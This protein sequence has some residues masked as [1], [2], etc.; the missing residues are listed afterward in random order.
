MKRIISVL[1]LF[2]LLSSLPLFAAGIRENASAGSGSSVWKISKDGNIM[3]LA[4]SIHI[5]RESD[6]PLP[7]EFDYAFSKSQILV[8]EADAD[9][10][11]DPEIMEYI[12]THMFLPGETMLQD[13]LEPETYELLSSVCEEYGIPIETLSKIK[14]S[15]IIN[16]LTL[17][18]IQGYDFTQ[19]GVDDYFLEKAKDEKKPVQFLESVQSQIDMLVTMGEGYENEYVLY[20]LQD[21][22]S[23]EEGLELFLAEWKN[24]E[25]AASQETL[26]EM[27]KVWPKIYKALITDRHDVWLPQ[28]KNFIA[29][30]QVYFVIAGLLHMH[31]PDGL[32]EVLEGFG[33]TV[34]QLGL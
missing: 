14:P 32:L 24:G 18:Q 17:F 10:M 31:G 3:Y 4:G 9:Q 1:T 6:F 26:T 21:M 23:M 19:Q 8:L 27:K 30:G 12:L 22:D 29:S 34:E 7:R 15:M 25:A 28:I 11:T 13:L 33:Y 2:L 20:S 16:M 5:L